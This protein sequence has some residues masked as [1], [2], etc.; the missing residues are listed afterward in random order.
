MPC[1]RGRIQLKIRIK[2]KKN[3]RIKIASKWGSRVEEKDKDC[4]QIG[5]GCP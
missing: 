3:I 2:I 4:M 5:V 1:R